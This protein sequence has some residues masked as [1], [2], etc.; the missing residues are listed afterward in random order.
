M[1]GLNGIKL[2]WLG[3]QGI[4]PSPA[5]P[6]PPPLERQDRNKGEKNDD[7]SY[8]TDSSIE[9]D[10]LQVVMRDLYNDDKKL[11]DGHWFF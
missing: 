9:E 3:E 11:T 6:F 1:P 5:A 4:V 8:A 10:L 2:K 7:S